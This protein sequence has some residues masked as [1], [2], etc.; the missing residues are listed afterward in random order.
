TVTGLAVGAAQRLA[1][2]AYA[3]VKGQW[4]LVCAAGF[5]VGLPGGSLAADLLLGGL[6]STA[7]FATFLG[8]AGLIVGTLTV[9]G[10]VQIA[11]ALPVQRAVEHLSGP[12]LSRGRSSPYAFYIGI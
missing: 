5:G 9:R 8:I 10:S 3:T 4:V 6:Q 12:R 7:G 11:S 2:R 1:L